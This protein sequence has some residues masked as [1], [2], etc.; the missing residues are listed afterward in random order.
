[1]SAVV[2]VTVAGLYRIFCPYQRFRLQQIYRNEKYNGWILG[3]GQ[4]DAFFENTTRVT[5]A[6][7]YAATEFRVAGSC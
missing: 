5:S 1:M 2:Q 6:N 4:I 3:T 7:G